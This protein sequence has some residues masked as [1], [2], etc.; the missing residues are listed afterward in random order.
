MS[1]EMILV[2]SGFIIPSNRLFSVV[3]KDTTYRNSI[4][5]KKSGTGMK[6]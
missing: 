6:H 2:S 5:S 4:L 3:T 1:K